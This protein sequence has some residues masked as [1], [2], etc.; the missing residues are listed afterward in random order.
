M[1]VSGLYHNV[2]L[3]IVFARPLLLLESLT[4]LKCGCS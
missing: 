1:Q 3:L 4:L 2:I